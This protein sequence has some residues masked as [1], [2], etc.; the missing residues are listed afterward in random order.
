[1]LL[2]IDQSMILILIRL[3]DLPKIMCHLETI[4]EAI[5]YSSFLFNAE[6]FSFSLQSKAGLVIFCNSPCAFCFVASGIRG[7]PPR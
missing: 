5:F 4:I 2:D 1:M 7:A 3:F 6:P